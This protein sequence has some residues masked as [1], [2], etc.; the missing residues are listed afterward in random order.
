MKTPVWVGLKIPSL[1][2]H[3]LLTGL[4][5]AGPLVEWDAHKRLHYT[6]ADEHPYINGTHFGKSQLRD[7]IEQC[8][9]TCQFTR[10][11][12]GLIKTVFS[13]IT[14][15]NS[16]SVTGVGSRKMGVQQVLWWCLH[17]GKSVEQS[18]LLGLQWWCFKG[19]GSVAG[20]QHWSTVESHM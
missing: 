6:A 17:S 16:D 8:F 7:N 13:D 1:D 4:V 11:I 12:G 2:T 14:L 20:V 9:Q 3:Q 18:A 15:G 19:K 5:W 10:I